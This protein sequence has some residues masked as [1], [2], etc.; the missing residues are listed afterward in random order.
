MA[1]A[2][3]IHGQMSF[4]MTD[5]ATRRRIMVDTQI[6]PSD[7]TKYQIIDAF[8]SVPRETFVPDAQREAAYA[9]EDL[10]LAK[11]RVVLEPR[12]L[13]K[14]LDF[15]DI[16]PDE[17]VLDIGSG[18]GYSAAVIARLAQAVIAVEEDES[19]S[20]EAQTALADTGADNAVLHVG[21]LTDGAAEH[22]PYDV[23]IV[24]GGTEE[25]P[26]KLQKQLKD[27]G[28]IASIFMKGALGE[29]RI[30]RKNGDQITWRLAFNAVAPVLPGFEK[31]AEFSL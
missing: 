26:E 11:N 8:L 25:I 7:V 12:T 5:F 30:G 21:A 1:Q 10:P 27:G 16:G 2:A 29:V 17:L 4:G 15:L 28:R 14:M 24:Q 3:L 13:A 6:R 20:E 31:Q 22:G 18:M 23:I 19:L 9:G